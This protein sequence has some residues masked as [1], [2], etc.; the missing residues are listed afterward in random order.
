VDERIGLTLRELLSC[1]VV[2]SLPEAVNPAYF[3]LNAQ[4]TVNRLRFYHLKNETM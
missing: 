3:M 1:L 2:S 4:Y